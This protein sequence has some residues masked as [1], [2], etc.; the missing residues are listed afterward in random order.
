MPDARVTSES[1]VGP[2]LLDRVRAEIRAK[3]YS[4]HT[5][6]A[7][8]TWIRRFIFFHGKRHPETLGAPEVNAFL[9]HLATGGA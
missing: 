7:Y 2:R 5:E 4:P 8:A 9:A 3:H 1:R 6:A